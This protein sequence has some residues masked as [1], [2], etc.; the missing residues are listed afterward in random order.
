MA[1]GSDVLSM[2]IP[3]GGWAITGHDYE[4]IQ[5]LE[6]EPI[7]KKEFEAGFAKYDAWKAQQDATQ[8]TAKAALLNRLG[9]TED[10]AKLLLS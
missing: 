10:E 5:F 7:S 9:I 3:N 1:K 2:L 6:C 4:G 8:A